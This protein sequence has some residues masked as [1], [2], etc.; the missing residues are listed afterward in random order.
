MSV[1]NN[2]RKCWV[3]GRTEEDI[4]RE[5]ACSPKLNDADCF[6]WIGVQICDVCEEI[7][8]STMLRNN[9]ICDSGVCEIIARE[10][11]TVLKSLL[12]IDTG[13]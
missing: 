8:I 10:R 11:G 7:L 9:F 5:C 12:G 1:N 2:P 3:C 4:D 6:S 13:L